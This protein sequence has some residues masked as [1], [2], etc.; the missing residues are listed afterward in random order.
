MR[1][2]GG[3]GSRTD[4]E[5]NVTTGDGDVSLE[6]P[7]GFGADVDARTGDGRVRI[8]SITDTTDAGKNE[9]EERESVAG[10]L[11]GGG[12]ALR[13]RTSSGSITVKRW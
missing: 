11:G 13:I 5:W 8:D 1:E 2:R 10:K 4:G 3:P 6:V 7:E 9:G 12:K